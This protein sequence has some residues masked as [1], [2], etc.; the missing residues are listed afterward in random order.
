MIPKVLLSSDGSG[1]LSTTV[2]GAILVLIPQLIAFF[3]ALGV[4]I[5]ETSA[6]TAAT[7]LLELVGLATVVFG[8]VNAKRNLSA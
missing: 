3:R 2:T 6:M 4:E 5:D 8:Y 1:R 7:T